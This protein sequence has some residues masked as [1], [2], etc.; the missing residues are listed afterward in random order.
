MTI[1]ARRED[2]LIVEDGQK[3]ILLITAIITA[4]AGGQALFKGVKSPYARKS[5]PG[6]ICTS[7]NEQ[8]VHGIPSEKVK[9]KEGDIL[10]VDFGVK[11]DGYCGDAAF[12]TGI[13]KIS[14]DKQ[15]LIDVTKKLLD[16]AIATLP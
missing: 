14:E 1:T 8:V 16:I 12:T 2:F 9:V 4:A 7:I 3:P 6:A 15:R 10:S 5:F 13:G 11:L